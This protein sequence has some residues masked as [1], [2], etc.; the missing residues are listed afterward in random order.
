MPGKTSQDVISW[1]KRSLRRSA[2]LKRI[3][4]F[5]VS[6]IDS[7]KLK[8][9][10]ISF[11]LTWPGQDGLDRPLLRAGASLYKQQREVI[12]SSIVL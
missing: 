11:L 8:M 1:V 5:R 2:K 4:P 12:Y 10:M 9:D 3:A 7:H 6:S